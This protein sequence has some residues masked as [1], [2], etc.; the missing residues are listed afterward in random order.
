MGPTKPNRLRPLNLMGAGK[1]E[2]S[3]QTEG[4]KGRVTS[5]PGGEGAL[6][7]AD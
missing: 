5:G 2:D 7:I 4:D 3:A 6:G 1:R